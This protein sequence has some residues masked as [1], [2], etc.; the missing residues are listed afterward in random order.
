MEYRP[1]WNTYLSKVKKKIEI[2]DSSLFSS[3]VEESRILL[4]TY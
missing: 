3:Y 4:D 1:Q 2:P